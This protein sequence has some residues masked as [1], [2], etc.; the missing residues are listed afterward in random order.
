MTSYGPERLTGSAPSVGI[1][2]FFWSSSFSANAT[3]NVRFAALDTMY[4]RLLKA[5]EN[6][7][8]M[9]RPI[10]T[11]RINSATIWRKQGHSRDFHQIGAGVSE[12]AGGGRARSLY[13]AALTR[14]I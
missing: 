13:S 12:G 4:V 7:K 5:Q 14:R 6:G 3:S 10:R 11:T 1:A 8:R 9:A 2:P